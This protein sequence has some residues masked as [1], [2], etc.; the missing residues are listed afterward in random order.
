[1]CKKEPKCSDSEDNKNSN[2][3][4]ED[5]VM[6]ELSRAAN[7]LRVGDSRFSDSRPDYVDPTPFGC[8]MGKDWE[9]WLSC[10]IK[11]RKET[12]TKIGKFYNFSSDNSNP[13][14]IF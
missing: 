6:E 14:R 7:D 10:R 4:C 9:I 11:P 5:F 12:L 8:P 3:D 1:M 13:T 2:A